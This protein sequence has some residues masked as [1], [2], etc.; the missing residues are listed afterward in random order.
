[1][2][3]ESEAEMINNIFEFG[4]KAA[5]DIMTDRSNVVADITLIDMIKKSL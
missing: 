3:E 2:I 5:K 1:M 4:D